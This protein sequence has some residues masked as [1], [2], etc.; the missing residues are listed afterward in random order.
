MTTAPTEGFINEGGIDGDG[1]N[2]A[3]LLQRHGVEA[4]CQTFPESGTPQDAKVVLDWIVFLAI[5]V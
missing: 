1:S 3:D 2:A 4:I 5:L